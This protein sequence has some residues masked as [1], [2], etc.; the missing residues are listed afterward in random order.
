VI[1]QLRRLGVHVAVYGAG[2]AFG[3]RH[4]EQYC[5]VRYEDLL[6]SPR[7][8]VRRVLAWLGLEDDLEKVMAPGFDDH[9]QK[10]D[11]RIG[12][13]RAIYSAQAAELYARHAGAML[14][15]YGYTP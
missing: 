14:A 13:W 12:V 9:V 4:P 5:E 3:Q 6:R 1:E 10:P 11:E 2:L 7:R 8:E 15:R